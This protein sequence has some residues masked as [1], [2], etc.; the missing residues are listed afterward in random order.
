MTLA[1]PITTSAGYATTLQKFVIVGQILIGNGT[2]TLNEYD[3]IPSAQTNA[4]RAVVEAPTASVSLAELRRLSG[5][6]WEQLA[7]IFGVSRRAIHFWASGKPMARS[8]EEHLYQLLAF[9]RRIDRGSVAENRAALLEALDIKP[10]AVDL[11]ARY[12]YKR[13]TSPASRVSAPVR[14]ARKPSPPDELVGALHDT[15][16]QDR[17]PGRPAR[18]V[19]VRPQK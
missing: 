1:V 15:V 12:D 7:S 9:V 19:K 18:S 16:H 4:G 13:A 10:A 2:S 17:G 14:L 6:N 8:N 11:L 5:L 3:V